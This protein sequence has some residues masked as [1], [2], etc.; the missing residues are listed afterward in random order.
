VK[1]LS[2]FTA[3]VTALF[4]VNA[5]AVDIQDAYDECGPGEGYDKY[6]E[7]DA[8]ENYTGWLIVDS[9]ADSCIAGNG[10]TVQLD[11]GRT[12]RATDAGTKMDID[13]AVIY[14]DGSGSGISYINGAQGTVNFCTVDNCEYGLFVWG[15]SNVTLKNSIITNNT[16]YGVAKEEYTPMHISYVDAWGNSQGNYY[17]YCSG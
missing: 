1:Y 15:Y 9:G 4:V 10:A 5:L 3:V 16:K 6:L 7:L 12:I 13:H 8:N 11:S 14:C 2:I 17:Q